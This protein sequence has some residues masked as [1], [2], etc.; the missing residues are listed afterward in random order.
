MDDGIDVAI[1]GGGVIGL[2]IARELSKDYSVMLFEK[3]HFL[4][5]GQS[6]HFSGVI[7]SG[8]YYPKKSKKAIHCVQGN[9]DIYSFCETYNVPY[10]SAPKVIVAKQ[11]G[12][13]GVLEEL[14]R[15]GMEN[16]VSGVRLLTQKEIQLYE[17]HVA[18]VCALLCPTTGIIDGPTFL[19]TLAG[20]AQEQG[21]HILKNTEITK[22]SQ[23]SEGFVLSAVYYEKNAAA[24]K[25]ELFSYV[26]KD[27]GEICA[28]YV[29]NAAGLYSDVTAKL[30]NPES[31]W[32]IIP[33]RGEYYE[34]HGE[35]AKLIRGNVYPVPEEL[36]LGIHLTPTMGDIMTI[37]PSAKVI[38]LKDDYEH[39]RLSK[40]LFYVAANS[41]FRDK[42]FSL[43][44]LKMG[45]TGI[46]AK[47]KNGTDWV[48]ARDKKYSHAIHC[49]GI[50]SPGFTASLSI[51]KNEIKVLIDE[52]EK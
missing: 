22:I 30:I 50:D 43:E 5:E 7:H 15:C 9:K 49:V 11:I 19:K 26:A 16:K 2:A 48:I 21:A 34:V 18:G 40:E 37:G 42:P 36:G 4:G 14:L 10:K 3:S 39:D 17:P 51:A 1:I 24:K 44:D 29:I 52:M 25:E 41:F 13:K 28:K 23:R 45:Y 31:P 32:E 33:V 20:H 12:E 46:R 6:G 27:R 38:A 47:L 35:K 8:L